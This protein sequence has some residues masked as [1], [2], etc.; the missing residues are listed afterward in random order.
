MPLHMGLH[1]SRRHQANDVVKRLEFAR[2]MMGRSTSFDTGQAR[3][4]LLK[5]CQHIAPLELASKDDKALRIDTV[6]LK[7]RL[8][9]VGPIVVIVC[10]TW[11]LRIM[12]ALT[13]PHPWHSRAWLPRFMLI[14]EATIS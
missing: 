4:Q 7:N 14:S 3:W 13:A 9:D 11:L 2:P 5:E 8:R 10:M 6:D 1:I 12:G